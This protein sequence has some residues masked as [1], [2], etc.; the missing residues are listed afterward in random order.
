MDE[1]VEFYCH[2][3]YVWAEQFDKFLNCCVAS[4]KRSRV[5]LLS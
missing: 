4:G 2:F 3:D 5:L 1:W